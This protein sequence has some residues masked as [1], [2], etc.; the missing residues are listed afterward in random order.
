MI[1]YVLWALLL[2]GIAVLEG[3]SVTLRSH[4]WPSLSDMF[5][6]ATRPELGRWLVFALWLWLGW[7]LFIRGWSFFLRGHG[8]GAPAKGLAPG[9]TVIQ[10]LQQ[11]VLPLVLVYG[12]CMAMLAAGYR[13]R[14]SRAGAA[15]LRETAATIARHRREFLRFAVVTLAASYALFVAMV[16]GYQL[17]AGHAGSG[18]AAS[19]L[20]DGAFLTF[21]VAL[22]VFVAVSLVFAALA[23]RRKVGCAGS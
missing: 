20:T 5:R 15:P 17:I 16:G 13:T 8:G 12:A 3:L 23:A 10:T 11:I 21:A 7:H 22:P 1:G 4:Q 19:A 18:L 9:T 14:R 2:A 6:A